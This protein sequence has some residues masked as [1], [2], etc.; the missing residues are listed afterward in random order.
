M[1]LARNKK[2]ISPLIASVLLIVVVVGIGAVITGIVRNYVTEGKQTITEK[3]SDMK[4]GTEIMIEVPVVASE[5]KICKN[6]TAETITFILQNTGSAM[7]DDLQVKVFGT[8]GFDAVDTVIT[9]T[10]AAGLA[11]G[12]TSSYTVSY[13]ALSVGDILEVKLV[14]RIKVVGRTEKAYCTDS[15]LTFADLGD[16]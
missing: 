15:G 7:I 13:D 8:N 3:S 9:D 12:N 10:G 2:A 4:C 16:C 14:P 1:R 6:Q 11:V 5:M